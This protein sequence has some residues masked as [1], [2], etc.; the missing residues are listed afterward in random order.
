MTTGTTQAL[1]VAV[2]ATVSLAMTPAPTATTWHV[3]PNHT[4]VG[5]S[6][7][8]F[9]TP[10]TGKFENFDVDLRYDPEQPEAS[11]VEVVVDVGSVNT[12]N[13]R[14]D[15]HLLSADF[16]EA[17]D[18]PRM[19][20]RSESIR[21]TGPNTLVATGPLTI[22]GVTRTVELPIEVLGIKDIPEDMRE[23]LGGATRV[24][25][26][27][28]TTTV[29]R[30]DFGVGV[31]DWAAALVVGHEVTIDVTAEAALRN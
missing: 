10:V 22:K 29:D 1:A 17:V 21:Q 23:M 30:G 2:L 15:N 7:K 9:F 4:E 13:E 25:S 8:H 6:V 12:N 19:T 18:H 16:F 26:F 11:S 31:G 24:A 27:R 20:F 28:A 3:D 14:R 5:F